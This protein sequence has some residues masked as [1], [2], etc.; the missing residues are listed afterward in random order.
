MHVIQLARAQWLVLDDHVKPRYL[1]VQ[2]PV[3][4]RAT[5]ETEIMHRVEWWN[6][7]RAKRHILAVCDGQV[8]AEAWCRHQLA[9]D[10]A[11]RA[12]IS[13]SVARQGW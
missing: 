2:G 13:A 10:A 3:V 4:S 12:E 11:K 5:G 1:I 7:D 9:V 8:A 6:P